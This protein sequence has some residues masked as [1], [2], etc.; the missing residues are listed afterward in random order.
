MFAKTAAS[1]AF[2]LAVLAASPAAVFAA[3]TPSVKVSLNDLDL[4][5][6]N[7]QAT[8][9]G[10][11]QHAAAV[12]CGGDEVRRSLGDQQAYKACRA[13]TVADAM[14]QIHAAVAAAEHPEQYAMAP[15]TNH[16]HSESAAD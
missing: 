5:S 16:S 4:A 6:A 2:T 14:P 12:I 7:G 13:E 15:H 9:M 11:V 10:R 8:L 1:I 3:E